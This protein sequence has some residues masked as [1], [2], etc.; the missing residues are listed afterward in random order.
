MQNCR[1][2][3][4]DPTRSPRRLMN[5]EPDPIPPELHQGSRMI[6]GTQ[7]PSWTGIQLQLGAAAPAIRQLSKS[8]DSTDIRLVYRPDREKLGPY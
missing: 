2:L 3:G 4:L 1:P 8:L 5:Q 6:Q 7:H